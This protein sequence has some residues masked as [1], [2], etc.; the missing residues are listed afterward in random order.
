MA[1]P[2]KENDL[3]RVHLT[4][5]KR[6]RGLVLSVDFRGNAHV[7]FG[8]IGVK[9]VQL[10]G[11]TV[12]GSRRCPWEIVVEGRSECFQKLLKALDAPGVYIDDQESI[13]RRLKDGYALT[14]EGLALEA[15]R[16]ALTSEG[17]TPE[18]LTHLHR[19]VLLPIL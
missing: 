11:A 3:V 6:K 5:V 2:P 12:S 18:G 9:E 10:G 13:R 14:P 15:E 16:L 8:S 7:F 4:A 19:R 17:L 1:T